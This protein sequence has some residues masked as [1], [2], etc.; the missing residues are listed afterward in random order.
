MGKNY[1]E[2]GYADNED[3]T[4]TFTYADCQWTINPDDRAIVSAD[5]DGSATMDTGV[6][7]E[8]DEKAKTLCIEI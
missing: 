4:V 2:I 3:G 6:I 7:L 5:N 1:K 8:I